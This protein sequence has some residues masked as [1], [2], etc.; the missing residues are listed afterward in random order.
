MTQLDQGFARRGPR[1]RGRL[2]PPFQTAAWFGTRPGRNPAARDDAA[3]ERWQCA[4]MALT[5]EGMMKFKAGL[6]PDQGMT[7]RG[8][9]VN[10]RIGPGARREQPV[11][12]RSRQSDRL[13]YHDARHGLPIDRPGRSGDEA[14]S[15]SP[16]SCPPPL[17]GTTC[18]AIPRRRQRRG[19]TAR[20]SARGTPLARRPVTVRQMLGR[21]RGQALF[22][23]RP[24]Q[25]LR[26][27]EMEASSGIEPE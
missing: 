6:F 17:T 12:R 4:G 21:Q 1:C 10:R 15:I 7:I 23:A 27:K 13:G 26:M 24:D 9:R 8:D 18:V 20:R 11:I 19:K 16:A 2:S 3:G 14:C 25:Q 22:S 5:C